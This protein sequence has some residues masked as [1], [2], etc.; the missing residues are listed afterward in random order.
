MFLLPPTPLRFITLKRSTSLQLLV[1]DDV[2]DERIHCYAQPT[3]GKE[4][5]RK[6][7]EACQAW[8]VTVLDSR[9]KQTLRLDRLLR[10]SDSQKRHY[11][12]VDKQRGMP[13]SAI[14]TQVGAGVDAK[15]SH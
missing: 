2:A 8:L 15:T 12:N 13:A 9:R 11:A 3:F 7:T 10:L 14:L 5:V 1:K 4:L 6:A